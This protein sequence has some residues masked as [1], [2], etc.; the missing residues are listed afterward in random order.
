MK[1][2]I[3]LQDAM[4]KVAGAVKCVETPVKDAIKGHH[5]PPSSWPAYL[6]LERVWN[7]KECEGCI[8]DEGKNLNTWSSR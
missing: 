2:E 3:V 6:L 4:A 1:H 5:A 7:E 8:Y